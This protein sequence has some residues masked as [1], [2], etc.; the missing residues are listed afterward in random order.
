MNKI[1]ITLETEADIMTVNVN[2]NVLIKQLIE[3]G[4]SFKEYTIQE[5]K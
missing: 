1:I 4:L 2:M 3:A 5:A